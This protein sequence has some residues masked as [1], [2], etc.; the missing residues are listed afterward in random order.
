MVEMKCGC[1][2]VWLKL[3]TWPRSTILGIP[4]IARRPG[5]RKGTCSIRDGGGPM[6][7]HIANPK[8]YLAS[9]LLPKKYKT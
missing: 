3:D 1:R 7:L 4:F 6:E 8:K 2:F 5:P 9:K